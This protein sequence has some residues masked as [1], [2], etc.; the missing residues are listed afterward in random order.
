VA[1][2]LALAVGLFVVLRSGGESSDSTGGGSSTPPPPK[3]RRLHPVA[4]VAKHEL[5]APVSGEAAVGAPGRV[6][7]VSGLDSSDV[8]TARASVLHVAS[9]RFTPFPPLPEA[10]HDAAIAT[11]GGKVLIFGGGSLGELDSVES[12]SP[13]SSWE[14]VGRLPTTRSDLSAVNV[15]GQVYLLGGY[16]GNLPLAPVLRTGD[17]RSFSAVANLPIPFRYAAVVAIGKTIYTFGGV[18]ASGADTDAIQ[19]IDTRSGRARVIGHLDRPLS[20]ASAVALGGRA[21]V[22]GGRSQEVPTD[23]ILAFDP[24]TERLRPAGHLPFPVTNA[25]AAGVGDIGYLIGGLDTEGSSL[26]SVIEVRLGA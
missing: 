4:E 13:G 20:H 2:V 15:G 14:P 22:L 3:P 24:S 1:I 23:E 25:A 10:R 6:L 11:L 26:S 16:D 8:S 5:P 9:G 17:G 7:V 21:Y 12:L 19:A 18:L